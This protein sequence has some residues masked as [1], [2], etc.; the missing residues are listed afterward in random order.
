M[1]INSNSSALIPMSVRPENSQDKQESASLE[2]PAQNANVSGNREA[3]ETGK[4]V[5][6]SA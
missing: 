3:F 1:E 2:N 5:N 6:I 4:A